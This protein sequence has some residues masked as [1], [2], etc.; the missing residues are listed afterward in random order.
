SRVPPPPP[1]R[2][3]F[4]RNS[5]TSP[6]EIAKLACPQCA[7]FD[8]ST[9]QGLLNHCR[10]RHQ[11]EYGSHDECVQ[12]CAVLV[13]EE[14]REWVVQN[15]IEVAGI[16][17]PSLRRL[18]EIASGVDD[19]LGAP[20]APDVRVDT[21]APSTAVTRTLGYHADTPALAQFLGH[22]PKKRRI[23]NARANEDDPVDIE[24]VSAG[25]GQQPRS[26]W[27]KRY[28][29][30]N[31]ARKELDEVVP[32]SEPP[33][34]AIDE[35]V[36]RQEAQD[37]QP[38]SKRRPS[39]LHALAR[40]Q[41]NIRYQGTIPGQEQERK[42]EEE[43]EQGM[44]SCAISRCVVADVRAPYQGP[45]L[46][47]QQQTAVHARLHLG[48]VLNLHYGRRKAIEGEHERRARRTPSSC[49][50]NHPYIRHLKRSSAS[51]SPLTQLPTVDVFRWLHSIVPF[52]HTGRGRAAS[53][54]PACERVQHPAAS[55]SRQAPWRMVL[56]DLDHLGLTMLYDVSGEDGTALVDA[57][58]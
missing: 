23:N 3:L 12:R 30:R 20:S 14:E 50:I 48:P 51:A 38:S 58:P 35:S 57:A 47:R 24:D 43:E 28:V 8:F 42:Q 6:P 16:S 34:N 15:G 17:L 27:R 31:V 37:P 1:K 5:T 32:L 25:S 2:L 40:T 21:A 53:Q 19:E 36:H 54:A 33:T 52:E 26:R 4:L 29:H 56:L 7:R 39:G 11:L 49:P 10:L 18:F 9:L 46:R 45:K 44:A 55:A 41:F 13:P 22:A